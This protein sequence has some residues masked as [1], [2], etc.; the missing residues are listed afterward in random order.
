[1]RVEERIEVDAAPRRVWKLIQD[2]AALTGL[3]EGLTV[4]R[5]PETPKAGLRARYRILMHVGPVPIG[6]DVEIVEFSPGRELAW[7]S[8]T[9]IDQRFRVRLRELGPDRT[10]LVLRFGYSSVG[11]LGPLA[12]V[13]AYGRVRGL[14]RRLVVALKAEA[15]RPP[16]A[17]RRSASKGKGAA[18]RK[19]SGGAR[20]S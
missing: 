4:E 11:P 1:M 8:L 14:V 7:T 17:R 9:G 10:S 18:P 20:A 15:E 19:R 5:D 2:P 6:A 3:D 12:D 16:P 13:V